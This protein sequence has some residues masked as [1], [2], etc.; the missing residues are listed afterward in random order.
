MKL[1]A[2]RHVYLYA[3]GHYGSTG[4]VVKDMKLIISERYGQ[5]NP[6]YTDMNNWEESLVR[7]YDVVSALLNITFPYLQ[8]NGN[9]QYSYTEFIENCSSESSWKV[10]YRHNTTDNLSDE[11]RS[12]LEPYDYYTAVIHACLS[13]LRFLD[14]DTIKETENN[15]ELG[16]A[17]FNLFP[18]LKKEDK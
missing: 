7:K 11:Q 14:V 13:R 4:D 9:P 12:K 10:R 6:K 1:S 18:M 17:D 16:E 5:Y 2:N 15:E 8:E 3:K